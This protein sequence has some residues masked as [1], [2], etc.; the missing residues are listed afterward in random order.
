MK[1][2]ITLALVLLVIMMTASALAEEEELIPF[3]RIDSVEITE[4]S[5]DY[6]VMFSDPIEDYIFNNTEEI[7]EEYIELLSTTDLLDKQRLFVTLSI[8]D[9]AVDQVT[10]VIGSDMIGHIGFLQRS[11]AKSVADIL[12]D[13]L[14]DDLD[15]DFT[16]DIQYYISMLSEKSYYDALDTQNL[17]RDG[18]FYAII[19]LNDAEGTQLEDWEISIA[20]I[21]ASRRKFSYDVH[22]LP[23]GEHEYSVSVGGSEKQQGS[24]VVTEDSVEDDRTLDAGNV[25]IIEY[26]PIHHYTGVGK[27]NIYL[28]PV[29]ETEVSVSL[30]FAGEGFITESIPDYGDGWEVTIT[31]DGRID[32]EYDF[33]FYEGVVDAEAQYTHGWLIVQEELESFFRVNMRA[34]G[35]RGQEIEDFVEFWV[36]RLTDKPMYVICPQLNEDYDNL[37]ALTVEPKPDTVLRLAY[38]IRGVD[39]F[40]GPLQAPELP[41]ASFIVPQEREGFWVTEWGVLLTDEDFKQYIH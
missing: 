38:T 35:F 11:F 15:G 7:K 24:L 23:V 14:I 25:L 13:W 27:P 32:D 28:Y 34:Y 33:L 3:V 17:R 41:T 26:R 2:Q 12:H 16:V 6:D 39:I 5:V 4:A 22:Y 37:V 20:D 19:S 9:G 18:F 31:P 10:I 29:E 40:D 21:D 36:P 1:R 8:T 30:D